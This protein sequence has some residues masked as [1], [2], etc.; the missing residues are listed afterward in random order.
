MRQKSEIEMER[1]LLAKRLRAVIRLSFS[2]K[3][4]REVNRV[5]PKAL[6]EFDRRV[7]K[8]ELPSVAEIVGE[9]A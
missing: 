2:V 6:R 1:A 7:A 4:D 5:V 8:G 3:A 9:H